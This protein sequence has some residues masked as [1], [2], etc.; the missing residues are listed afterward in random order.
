M[1]KD[2]MT[3]QFE[4]DTELLCDNLNEVAEAFEKYQPFMKIRDEKQAF[5]LAENPQKFYD[6]TIVEKSNLRPT[7]SLPLKAVNVAQQLNLDRKGFQQ[8]IRLPKTATEIPVYATVYLHQD[9]KQ[10]F[11]WSG[12]F[13]IDRK[14][15]KKAI[16]N[17]KIQQS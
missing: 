11:T 17:L 8:A 9:K 3:K 16:E 7:G 2:L 6:L 5:A 4:L 13:R 15:L 12:K 1:R 14:A 10:L